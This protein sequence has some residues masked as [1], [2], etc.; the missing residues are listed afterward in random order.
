MLLKSQ[1]PKCWIFFKCQTQ[2]KNI[3][4]NLNTK[5]NPD[6]AEIFNHLI[7]AGGGGVIY[8]PPLIS[9]H[10]GLKGTN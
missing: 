6:R 7:H 3:I 9:V 4:R 2:P 8:D 5:I 10:S 1:I